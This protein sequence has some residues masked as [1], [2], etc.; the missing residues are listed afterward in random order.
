MSATAAVA[1]EHDTVAMDIILTRLRRWQELLRAAKGSLLSPEEQL[2]LFGELL[3]LRDAFVANLPPSDA[4]ACW[5][6]PLGDEQDFGYRG[7]LLETKSVRITRD[8]SFTV[9]SAAQLDTSSGNIMVAFQTISV[10]DR[11]P[12]HGVTL[13]AL[14][15]QIRSQ[16]GTNAAAISEF[17][18]RLAG[19][20]YFQ[21]PEYDRL[22]FMPASRRIFEVLDSFPRI[23]T[24]D[25]RPGLSKISYTVDVTRCLPF[26]IDAQTAVSRILKGTATAQLKELDVAAEDLVRF[27]ESTELEFKSSMR[28]SY[29][30]S[31]V[32]GTL[33][34]V[35]LKTIAALANTRG[36]NLV[37]GVDDTK[38]VLGLEKDYATLKTHQNRDGFEQHLVQLLLN[39]FGSVFCT[40][41]VQISFHKVEAQEVCVVAVKRVD[42]IVSVDKVD[43][44]GSK[45]RAFYIRAGNSS[46]EL[47]ADEVIDYHEGRRL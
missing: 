36:G 8:K 27:D 6:G 25:L 17:D 43:R 22:H 10:S 3:L 12:P 40:R 33:E 24:G 37:I 20:N 41:N 45:S 32:D 34:F 21:D 47:G 31:K 15:H 19:S 5:T 44:S 23:E 18:M 1:P 16:L 9:N 38:T 4:V 26:E 39:A 7:N 29:R 46:R 2:G 13:N 14:V 11:A 30:E 42:K 28:W 35:I